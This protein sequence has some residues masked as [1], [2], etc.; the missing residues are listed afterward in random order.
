MKTVFL[1]KERSENAIRFNPG[2]ARD[3]QKVSYSHQA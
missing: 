3:I 2:L 1:K